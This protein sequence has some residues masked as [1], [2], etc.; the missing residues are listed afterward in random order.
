MS[1]KKHFG[2]RVGAGILCAALATLV[3]GAAGAQSRD[4]F[5]ADGLKRRGDGTIDDSQAGR[6]GG[7]VSDDLGA[8]GLKRR[9]DGSIDDSQPGRSRSRS[10][11]S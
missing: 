7:R 10:S 1:I 3:A 4:D 11:R 9:G 8:D 5:G 6:R 2:K